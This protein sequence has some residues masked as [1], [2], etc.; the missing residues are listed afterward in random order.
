MKGTGARRAALLVSGGLAA[1][2]LG[3]FFASPASAHGDTSKFQ[4]KNY[5]VTYSDPVFKDGQTTFKITL[6]GTEP[7]S[8]VLIVPCGSPTL[9]SASGPAGA[10]QPETGN[11]GSTGHTGTKFP[12]GAIG[13]YTI[14]YQGQVNGLDFIVKNG[15]GHQHYAVES[16]TTQT[17]TPPAAENP[18]ETPTSTTP[19]S[20]TPTSSTP[21]SST[22]T[23]ST[24]TSSTPGQPSQP[25][26]E[27]AGTNQAKPG[28]TVLGE[29]LT[30]PEPQ[31]ALPRTGLPVPA[32]APIGT[33]LL[34]L[35]G[36]ATALGRRP[37]G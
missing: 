11:D 17:T 9:V 26:A 34:A 23:S 15:D 20:S 35:G 18:P 32:L 7:A 14:V 12:K 21:T 29:Q 4:D 10:G 19:T 5:T 30:Q 33:M 6:N 1:V 22:P 27:V 13:E 28:T 2:M 8:H 24:P 16:C 3:G 37:R 31:V 25:G 36:L